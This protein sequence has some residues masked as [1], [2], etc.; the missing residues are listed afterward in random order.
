MASYLAKL[1][2]NPEGM[3]NEQK[4]KLKAIILPSQRGEE[5]E[6]DEENEKC[7]NSA[8]TSASSRG[9]REEFNS[10]FFSSLHRF[11]LRV[12]S[13]TSRFLSPKIKSD[14]NINGAFKRKFFVLSHELMFN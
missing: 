6:D 13:T 10:E 2:K 7:N 11:F 12:R 14:D 5:E 1:I 3:R 9:L 4:H 8:K